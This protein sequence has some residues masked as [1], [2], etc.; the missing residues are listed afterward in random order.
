MALGWVLA[1]GNPVVL[2]LVLIYFAVQYETTIAT[3]EA[4]LAEIFGD[5]WE[6]YTQEVSQ[7]IPRFKL[8]RGKAPVMTNG[9]YLR[10]ECSTSAVVVVL[11]LFAEL[12]KYLNYKDILP[13]P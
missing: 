10:R 8:P 11:L 12:I 5:E 13:L 3:E 9:C 6:R 4:V 1:L 7:F 2:I